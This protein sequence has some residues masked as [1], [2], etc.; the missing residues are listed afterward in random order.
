[1][2]SHSP[3][4]PIVVGLVLV[5]LGQLAQRLMPLF[6]RI[7]FQA[8]AEGSYRPEL[9]EMPLR[10]FY[11]AAVGLIALGIVLTILS[12]LRKDGTK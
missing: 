3:W 1:M 5:A 11:W 4:S 2:K 7:A 12:L 6:G 8:A 10:G 9:Y